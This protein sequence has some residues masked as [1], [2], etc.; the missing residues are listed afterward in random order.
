MLKRVQNY[1]VVAGIPI[2]SVNKRGCLRKKTEA[3]LQ[4]QDKRTKGGEDH[5]EEKKKKWNLVRC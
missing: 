4:K 5:G 1:V 2:A 3:C